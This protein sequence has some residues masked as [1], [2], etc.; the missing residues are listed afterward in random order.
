LTPSFSKMW[1]RWVFTVCGDM[2]NVSAISRSVLP[3]E[4]SWATGLPH[5]IQQ[6]AGQIGGDYHPDRNQDG[7]QRDVPLLSG[8][9]QAR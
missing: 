4:A 5:Q 9:E 8:L 6:L 3:S 2:N 7:P 1:R